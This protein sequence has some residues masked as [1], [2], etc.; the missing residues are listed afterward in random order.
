M[1]TSSSLNIT[2][3]TCALIDLKN[4][5]DKH[6]HTKYQENKK[7]KISVFIRY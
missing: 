2:P 3:V 5:S 4:P 6:L 7:I 1:D